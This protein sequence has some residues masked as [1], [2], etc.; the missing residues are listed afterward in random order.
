MQ[1]HQA[2]AGLEINQYLL[3][4]ISLGVRFYKT[5]HLNA[6]CGGIIGV[7]K[8]RRLTEIRRAWRWRTQLDPVAK[9]WPRAADSTMNT[10]RAD[11]AAKRMATIGG[12]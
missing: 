10:R 5:W 9:C 1:V 2:K 4:E 7:S 11:S 6:M 8:A 12:Q 3:F